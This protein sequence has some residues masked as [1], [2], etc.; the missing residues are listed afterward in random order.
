MRSF[1]PTKFFALTFV[2][3]GLCLIQ[4]REANAHTHSSNGQSVHHH[5]PELRLEN[6]LAV[7]SHSANPSLGYG[8]HW[9]DWASRFT[10]SLPSHKIYGRTNDLHPARPRDFKIHTG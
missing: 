10:L 2:C 3:F 1:H 9:L 8:H 7:H 5:C 4:S 6:G